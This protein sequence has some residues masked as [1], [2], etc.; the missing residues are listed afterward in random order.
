MPVIAKNPQW[1]LNG[2]EGG[3]GMRTLATEAAKAAAVAAGYCENI[4]ELAADI[5]YASLI[6]YNE[7]L[8]G[9]DYTTPFVEAMVNSMSMEEREEFDKTCKLVAG[10]KGM[11]EKATKDYCKIHG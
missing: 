2:L 4:N 11:D 8:P 3:E 7:S 9:L 6:G 10:F 5:A 1:G